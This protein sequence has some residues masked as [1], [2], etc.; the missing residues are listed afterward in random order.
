MKRAF[1][2][3]R[4]DGSI[5]VIVLTGKVFS[6]FAKIITQSIK[7]SFLKKSYCIECTMSYQEFFFQN[8]YFYNLFKYCCLFVWR[9]VVIMD[10]M[11]LQGTKAFCSGGDQ[12]V[13]NKDG[14]ADKND[15]GNL[16][17]LDLQ[18]LALH[19]IDVLTVLVLNLSESKFVIGLHKNC[20]FL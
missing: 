5:G 14:Y 16:N 6:L 11:L 3:A 19:S 1:D 4:E 20:T 8:F 12:S 17:V 7:I 10:E 18:V 9:V 15:L 2:D 13:R